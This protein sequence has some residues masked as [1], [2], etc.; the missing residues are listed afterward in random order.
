[1]L[2]ACAAGQHEGWRPSREEVAD[3]VAR[4]RGELSL[5]ELR[6]RARAR[7]ARSSS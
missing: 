4:A 5:E 3:L 6:D 1:M 7:A 2:Q